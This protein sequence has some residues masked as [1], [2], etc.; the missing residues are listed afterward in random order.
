M[1]K[2]KKSLAQNFIKDKNICVKIIKQASIRNNLVIEIGPGYGFLTNFILEKKPK[3][4][5]LIE[6]DN[7]IYKLLVQKYKNVNNIKIINDDA[8]NFDFKNYKNA[9][10][11]ANLPYNISAKLILKLFT[12]SQFIEEM[13]FLIQ[14]EVALK[15]DYKKKNLNKYK[16]FNKLISK[17]NICFNVPPTVFYPKPKV[18][19]SVV[20]FDFIKSKVDWKKAN[21]FSKQI[22]RNKR[23]KI[24]NNISIF[25]EE[26]KEL[27]NKRV[28][29]ITIFDLL[30]IY[31]SF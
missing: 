29:E 3:K 12:Y 11:L 1:L 14:K 13:I 22:F 17:Y 9:T 5:I 27:T 30:K 19:S 31:N 18:V 15:F 10:I 23:K 20:K 21:L 7:E 8:L 4:L 6:K 2:P 24:A 16:F 25:K 28:D 26:L